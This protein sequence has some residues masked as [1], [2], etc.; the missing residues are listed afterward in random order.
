MPLCISSRTDGTL[1]AL[2]TLICPIYGPRRPYRFSPPVD[3]IRPAIPSRQVQSLS[4]FVP[5]LSL[6]A[7]QRNPIINTGKCLRTVCEPQN[8]QARLVLLVTPDKGVLCPVM[9]PQ[10]FGQIRF[11][12]RICFPMFAL[13]CTRS[14][15]SGSSFGKRTAGG[16]PKECC[17][18]CRLV[19]NL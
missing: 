8:P 3:T 13:L 18:G 11:Q 14:V 2:L 10:A 4:S 9:A 6:S 16:E 19:L 12:A 7:A 15:Y 5:P 17:L 1:F